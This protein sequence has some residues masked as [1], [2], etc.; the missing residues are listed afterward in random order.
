MLDQI[1]KLVNDDA[2]LRRKGRYVNCVLMV[3]AG[4]ARYRFTIS[5][6]KIE[7]VETGRL[8]MAR[9][10][11]LMRAS[12]D[13]WNRFWEPMPAPGYNDLFAL[14]KKR[15]LTIEGD[16]QPFMANLFYFKG[17]LE[18]PRRLVPAGHVGGKL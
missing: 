3:E 14:L 10:D 7:S 15:L 11:V 2:F 5:G 16:V 18:M 13:T 4:G 6:G 17:V 9:Y 8:I 1:A 12:A